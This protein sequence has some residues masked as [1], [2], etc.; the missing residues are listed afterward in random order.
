MEI[1]PAAVRHKVLKKVS[2]LVWRLPWDGQDG[3]FLREDHVGFEFLE[4]GNGLQGLDEL[5]PEAQVEGEFCSAEVLLL[6]DQDGHGLKI[7]HLLVLLLLH[8]LH[9]LQ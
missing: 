6:V 1:L 8:F 3:R 5:A 2:F 4:V 7:D 9:D